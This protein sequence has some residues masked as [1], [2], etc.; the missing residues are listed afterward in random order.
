MTICSFDDFYSKSMFRDLLFHE[1]EHTFTLPQLDKIL[2][3]AIYNFAASAVPH[4]K[5][6]LMDKFGVDQSL[7]DFN[8]WHIIEQK[9]P[10]LFVGMYQFYCQKNSKNQKNSFV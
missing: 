10:D 4:Q 2:K 1:K 9:C 7:L 3:I 6:H 5:H 8:Q